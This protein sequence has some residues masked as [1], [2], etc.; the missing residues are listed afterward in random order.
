MS[1]QIS[2]IDI[3]RN[4]TAT[5][6]EPVH[7]SSGYKIFSAGDLGS[8]HVMAHRLF[9]TG[10]LKAG[11]QLLGERLAGRTGSGSEWIHLQFHL[12]LFELGLGDWE[13]AFARY[14][15]HISPAAAATD[16]ALTDAPALLWR[17]TLAA[18][19]GFRAPWA[20]LYQRAMTRFERP[21]QPFVEAHQLLAIAGAGD[22][23]RLDTWL[24]ARPRPARSIGEQFLVRFTGALRDYV[25]A[26]YGRAAAEL[27]RL[28]PRLGDIGGSRAQQQLFH[29]LAA[30]CRKR[31]QSSERLTA[32]AQAA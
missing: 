30:D 31:N 6:L 26:Q 23:S 7:D 21:C 20:P 32:L 2:N 18:P 13:A 29:E 1:D 8:L 5:S 27:D 14:E 15:E 9:D 19:E 4:R 24:Q 12:A 3:Y 28:L 17:L 10:R 22:K 25:S 11:R 16:E